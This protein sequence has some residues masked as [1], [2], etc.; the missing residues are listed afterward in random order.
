VA[1]RVLFVSGSVGLGHVTRDMA[2]AAELRRRHADVQV[3]WLAAGA[4]R[5]VLR[6]AGEELLPESDEY[7]DY[8]DERV[9][10]AAGR[11]PF[12]ANVLLA[13][14]A[15]REAVRANTGVLARLL[16]EDVCDVLVGDET[17][18]LTQLLAGRPELRRRPYVALLDFFGVEAVGWRPLEHLAARQF[19]RL[20]VRADERLF[21][22]G[23]YR[24]LFIGEPD[25]VPTGRLGLGLPRRRSFALEHYEFIGHV[26]RFSPDA[27]RDRTALRER[28]GYDA[29]PLIVATAGGTAA[30]GD[31]LQL[32]ADATPAIRERVPGARMVLVCGPG[33]ARS[34]LRV[35]DGVEVRGFVPDLAAHLAASDLAITQGGATTTLELTALRRPFLYFPLEGHFEQALVAKR[36]ARQRAGVRLRFSE[37]SATRLADEVAAHIGEPVEAEVPPLDGASKAADAILSMLPWGAT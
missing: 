19:N 24:C 12:N 11:R 28:L 3:V 15:A 25:D 31:L 36:L 22:A 2:I 27:Y 21:A 7:G 5:D 29:R 6:E 18:E 13:A 26:L 16:A 14:L 35:S 4:A 1:L 30:G 34:S 33:I 10:A 23:G 32:C 37:M 20:W 8:L 9:L 17:Y